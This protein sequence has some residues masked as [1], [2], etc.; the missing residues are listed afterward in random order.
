MS[1][2]VRSLVVDD[3]SAVRFVLTETLQRAGHQVTAAENGEEALEILRDN[4][5][6]L[7]IVDLRLGTRVDGLRVL[8]A[9][10][11]RWPHTGVILLTAHG[12]LDSAMAAIR[13][14]VDRYLLKPAEPGELLDTVREVLDRRRSNGRDSADVSDDALAHG[15]F[16]LQPEK[17]LALLEGRPLDLTPTEFSLLAYLVR[18][19]HRVC[20]PEEL[21]RATQGYEPDHLYEAR[22]V[23][24]WYVH[25]LRAKVESNPAQPRYI[26]NV[27]GVGYTLAAREPVSE[28][29]A[30]P[31]SN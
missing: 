8:E 28:P 26:V 13:E 4:C 3:D 7:A 23:I 16:V 2:A 24:K 14:G 9:I 18:N 15:P 17:H 25:R 11:W 31:T 6:D 12:S 10:R 19:A 30:Q 29:A 20:T 1:E 22:Q 27:R 5:F 21:V